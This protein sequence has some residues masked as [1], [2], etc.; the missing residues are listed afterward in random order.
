VKPARSKPPS[1]LTL[2]VALT[3]VAG[4]VDA[5]GFLRLGHYFVSF[6][7]GDSTQLAVS[8]LSR[9][10]QDAA[11]AGS[12]VALF[13]AGVIAGRLLAKSAGEWGRP[14]VLLIEALLLV[15]AATAGSSSAAVTVPIV[16][17]MGVQN[18]AIDKE[19]AATM[20]LSYVTGTLV[21]LGDRLADALHTG[22]P[23]TRWGWLPHLAHWLGLVGGAACGA[24]TYNLLERKAL[25]CPA[26]IAAIIAAVTAVG[27]Q[28]RRAR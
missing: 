4:W 7:S 13:V 2:A 5:I 20:G 25:L 18:A 1:Y 17:A 28:R 9:K 26:V 22:D 12:I 19:R 11:G 14:V 8:S 16:L 23:A 10:W 24:L 15:L 27:L 6:M 21:H 3:A